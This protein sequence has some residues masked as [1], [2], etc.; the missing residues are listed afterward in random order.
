MATIASLYV[1]GSVAMAAVLIADNVRLLRRGGV[2]DAKENGK[3]VGWTFFFMIAEMWWAG[4]SAWVLFQGLVPP[5]LPV[6]YLAYVG[7]ALL[8]G[9]VVNAVK[10]P[11]LSFPVWQVRAGLAFSV[12]FGLTTIYELVRMSTANAA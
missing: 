1:V 11:V 8:S 3:A 9:V 12:L 4:T 5:L 2:A 6:L 10:G 7:V